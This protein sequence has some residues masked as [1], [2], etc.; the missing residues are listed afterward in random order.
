[1]CIRDR[2]VTSE[3]ISNHVLNPRFVIEQSKPRLIDDLKASRVNDTT[4]CSDTYRPDTLGNLIL[5]MK[6]IRTADKDAELLAFAFD[7]KSAYK[8]IGVSEDSD[9]VARLVIL[10]PKTKQPYWCKMKCQPFGSRV[11]PRNWG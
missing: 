5:Q 9:K 1:M 2:P 7:F 6:R 10:D 3:I 11:S 8:H 4:S